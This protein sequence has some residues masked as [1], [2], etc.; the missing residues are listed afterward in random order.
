MTCVF[1]NTLILLLCA[2]TLSDDHVWEYA[3]TRT[4]TPSKGPW[5]V[6]LHPETTHDHFGSGLRSLQDQ[7]KPFLDS[8]AVVTHRFERLLHATVV[9]GISKSDLLR[10]S[11]VKRVVPNTTKKILR[12]SA[13]NK[14]LES[15]SFAIPWGLDR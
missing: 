13:E 14:S 6:H 3:N 12:V 5:I 8:E 2:Y 10:I 15:S 9:E 4:K 7:Q 11:G 1:R